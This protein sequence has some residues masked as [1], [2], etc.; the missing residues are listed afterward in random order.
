MLISLRSDHKEHLQLLTTQPLQVVVDFCKLALDF[1]QNGPNLKR[2][3]TAAQKLEVDVDVVQNCVFG[4]INLLILSCKHKLSEADFRDSVLTL[5]FSQEHQAVL[6]KFYE[7]K[8]NDIHRINHICIN[9]PHY[10]DLKWRFEVQVS[11]RSLLQQV[12]PLIA[13]ELV[14][15]TQSDNGTEKESIL[16]QTDPNNLLHIANELEHALSESRSRHSR[17]IQRALTH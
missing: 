15:K 4:L 7:S 16:L 10:E 13:M 2:Y 11:S 8:Q 5:G 14:L 3:T 1:L 9:E 17:K 6:S 12:T